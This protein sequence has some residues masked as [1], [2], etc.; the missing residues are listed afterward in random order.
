MNGFRLKQ[1]QGLKALAAHLHPNC[2][3]V[4]SPP[5]ARSAN[6]RTGFQDTTAGL[7]MFSLL[8]QIHVDPS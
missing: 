4:F 5:Y 2:P 1:G 6:N 8:D 7:S 3:K